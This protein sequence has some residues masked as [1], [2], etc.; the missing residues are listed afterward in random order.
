[1]S[2]Q[3]KPPA[4]SR[5]EPFLRFFRQRPT[6]RAATLLSGSLVWLVGFFLLPLAYLLA[7]SFARRSPY[8][9]IEWT[10]GFSNYWRAF[11]PLYLGVYWRSFWMA[12]LTTALCMLLGY[13]VA[14]TLALKVSG[15]WKSALLMLVVIPFWTSFLIRTYAW[16]VILR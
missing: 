16:M 4:V 12:L 7:V 10:L 13:P 2:Q 5:T 11:Q 15:R 9:T 1:M 6:I 14:Y 8:G 3:I